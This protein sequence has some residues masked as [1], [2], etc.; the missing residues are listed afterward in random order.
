MAQQGQRYEIA[1][2]PNKFSL[3]LSHYDRQQVTFR[4]NIGSVDCVVTGSQWEDGS[5]ESWLLEGN[6]RWLN[7]FPSWGPLPEDLPRKFRAWYRTDRRSG[8]FEFIG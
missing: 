4:L 3:M 5:G 2:G 1:G 8:W 7:P 6:I